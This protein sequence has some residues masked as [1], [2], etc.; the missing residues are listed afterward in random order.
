MWRIKLILFLL[1]IP[2][3]RIRAQGI[4]NLWLLGYDCGT[5]QLCGGSVID[6]ISGA[7]DTSK[8][9][10]PMNF[11]R[12]N[13]SICNSSGSLL[14]YTNGIYIANALDDTMLNGDNLSPSQFT[15]MW[16]QY[17]LSLPQ[18]SLILPVP[19]D[20]LRYVLFHETLEN[21]PTQ[22][23]YQP[24][25]LLYSEIDM[26]LDGGLGEVVLKNIP[27]ISDTLLISGITACKHANGRDW[28]IITHRYD[29][30][31][32]LTLLLTPY[33]ISGPF[34]QHAGPYI[35][36]G[37]G[38]QSV[39]SPDGKKF[40]RYQIDDDLDIFDFDRCSGTL[41]NPMHISIND[42][43]AGGGVAVSSNSKFLYV[44]SSNYVYQFDLTDT[45][46]ALTQSTIAVF[47][48]FTDP[49][50]PFYTDFYLAQLAPDNKIYIIT[51]NGTHYLHV[52]NNPDSAGMNC[53]LVQ[54]AFVLP[55][56]NAA[57]IPNYP[58]YFLGADSTNAICDSLNS[59]SEFLL[60]QTNELIIFPNP[61]T[62]KLYLNIPF[63][64]LTSDLKIYNVVG[65]EIML[66][67]KLVQEGSF[68]EFD[69]TQLVPG[70]YF[71]EFT[72]D[73]IPK[74]GRFIKE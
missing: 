28:W 21:I 13:S 1:L 19:G 73:D 33:G 72:K 37:G 34:I 3:S 11:F 52:I 25:E 30:D 48:N 68:F 29:S 8:V 46:V 41:S 14:F 15:T 55:T 31:I 50:P 42:S 67:P 49:A 32:Y 40:V 7:P 17:G 59:T 4:S 22:G 35:Y 45:N 65:Q 44:S 60:S 36:A 9:F 53:N 64:K 23:I 39:F 69:I 58:N 71:F 2:S 47:D 6:F 57:T 74:V 20:S 70:I 27:I 24:I 61:A 12:T 63:S 54:H 51:G 56:Y 5:V 43:A 18:A 62:D 10:R 66:F 38:D 16:D 26:S